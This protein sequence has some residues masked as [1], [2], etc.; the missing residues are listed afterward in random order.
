MVD[1]LSLLNHAPFRV[2]GSYFDV[3]SL[4]AFEVLCTSVAS[5]VNGAHELWR[6]LCLVLHPEARCLDVALLDRRT[7][8]GFALRRDADGLA[9]ERLPPGRCLQVRWERA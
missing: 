1:L 8:R 9:P 5:E 6:E 3:A 2:L 7:C 4:G